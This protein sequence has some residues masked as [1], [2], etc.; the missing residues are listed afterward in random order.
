LCL[1]YRW[2]GTGSTADILRYSISLDEVEKVSSLSTATDGGLA[3]L[4]TD[5]KSI[6]YFGG[7]Q[8]PT[9]VHKFNIETYLTVRL[10]TPLPSLI[11]L[12]GGVLKNRTMFIFNGPRNRILEFNQESE[13]AELIG[14]LPFHNESSTVYSTPAILTDQEGV[15]IF[16][17]NNPKATNPRYD[18]TTIFICCPCLSV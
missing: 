10:Q 7:F 18:S 14:E 13:T 11:N 9:S 4:A 17:G 1:I 3:L 15:W 5:E 16:A 6:Y 8:T 12:A 2:N